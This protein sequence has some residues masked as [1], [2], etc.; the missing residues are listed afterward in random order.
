MKREGYHGSVNNTAL[1]LNSREDHS[2]A[3]TGTTRSETRS[4]PLR[5]DVNGP[6]RKGSG[7]G[8]NKIISAAPF[9]NDKGVIK[10]DVNFRVER[11]DSA[12]CLAVDDVVGYEFVS[13]DG[14]WTWSIGTVLA[15][16]NNSD[17]IIGNGDGSGAIAADPNLVSLA[18][19]RIALDTQDEKRRSDSTMKAG[20]HGDEAQYDILRRL[21]EIEEEQ[22]EILREP[23]EKD[24][25]EAERTAEAAREKLRLRVQEQ[26]SVLQQLAKPPGVLRLATQA[27]FSLLGIELL[28]E[29]SEE[30]WEQ[31][32]R[33]LCSEAFEESL[34]EADTSRLDEVQAEIITQRFL[35]NPHFTY[36]Y[37][38][39]R[40]HLAALMQKWVVSEVQLYE[41]RAML[42]YLKGR[43][44]ALNE[45]ARQKQQELSFYLN[46]SGLTRTSSDQGD[47]E[48]V[49][50]ALRSFQ[51]LGKVPFVRSDKVAVVVR[52]SVFC[53]FV[54]STSFPMSALKSM[55]IQRDRLAC[56]R[57][58]ASGRQGRVGFGSPVGIASVMDN[59][60]HKSREAV[61]VKKLLYDQSM[62]RE[63]ILVRELETL[64]QK[65]VWYTTALHN[66]LRR[67]IA[68]GTS[69][70]RRSKSDAV[71]LPAAQKRVQELEGNLCEKERALRTM[72]T[73]HDEELQWMRKNM[74]SEVWEE[75][76]NAFD[77]ASMMQLRQFRIRHDEEVGRM[78]V[79]A[80]EARQWLA[81]LLFELRK[82]KD[83]AIAEMQ[84]EGLREL[85]LVRDELSICEKRQT[86]TVSILEDSLAYGGEEEG[87][88]R[89]KR[90]RRALK[91]ALKTLCGSHSSGPSSE[92]SL[93]RFS[94][95]P[96]PTQ[97]AA[98]RRLPLRTGTPVRRLSTSEV[99]E[100]S[101]ELAEDNAII[102]R[103]RLVE[104][105][106]D[107][108]LIQEVLVQ[109]QR[110][111]Q[112]L[113]EETKALRF[114]LSQEV[115]KH[116]ALKEMFRE[117]QNEV[118]ARP[119]TARSS[120]KG[121]RM[122]GSANDG[123][124]AREQVAK[125][126]GT[127]ATFDRQLE[128][129]LEA[130]GMKNEGA[131]L[132]ALRDC[133]ARLKASCAVM[134]E[135]RDAQAADA[136]MLESYLKTAA[137]ALEDALIHDERWRPH[138]TD[139]NYT[140]WH[141]KK[142]GGDDWGRVIADTPEALEK[143]LV[144]GVSSACHIPEE[145]VLNLK[146][147]DEGMS[148]YVS[149]DLRHDP[150]IPAEDITSR[151]EECNYYEL[152]RLYAHRFS[153]EEG[154][155]SLKRQL[156]AKEEE[157]EEL[158]ASVSHQR[159]EFQPSSG[160]GSKAY[161]LGA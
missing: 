134:Q 132:Q 158:R 112:L 31:M 152:E 89:H 3:S 6:W 107:R 81:L 5:R 79:A 41:A 133:F 126:R 63:H 7:G 88:E 113:E 114:D 52:S 145:Y 91:R 82:S 95:N 9:E 57:S 19:W 43:L 2:R 42:Q 48:N 33:V 20:K 35:N 135:E 130:E 22:A 71:Q 111:N 138:T 10:D 25:I 127:I 58:A 16:V 104:E 38:E 76:R 32:Q 156:R 18:Y 53:K 70:S 155:D 108:E 62:E 24:V 122:S 149:F 77:D 75:A 90:Q 14:R 92:S 67:A 78:R 59:E 119:G 109:E 36:A 68:A 69:F 61:Q 115:E 26:R 65:H 47:E 15:C 131:S 106:R 64:Y 1:L 101:R 150:T 116:A 148:L 13:E 12:S 37:M 157:L 153:P 44:S 98:Y 11:I 137:D 23:C 121:S 83:L 118:A 151:L 8:D 87:H 39:T 124:D 66:I 154:I 40:S 142:F 147:R 97:E 140:T 120:S 94:R 55:T 27:V 34:S 141:W 21:H 110:K 45:E 117:L 56:I 4:S 125:L 28:V 72:Q 30:E 80:K 144:R 60:L 85:N 29:R 73:K 96:T 86:K 160:G 100:V 54:P 99:S 17:N 50:Y 84:Q 161:V 103:D 159:R 123:R 128:E 139:S 143:A 93:R 74:R 102:L 51:D 46:V 146:Y 129:M 49:R 136:K 105:M